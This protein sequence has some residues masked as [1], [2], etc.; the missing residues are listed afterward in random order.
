MFL[1][2]V[3]ENP[4]T[5]RFLTRCIVSGGR[6]LTVGNEDSMAESSFLKFLVIGSKGDIGPFFLKVMTSSLQLFTG[7]KI[8]CLMIKTKRVLI[9]LSYEIRVKL[10]PKP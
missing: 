3:V 8:W 7:G 6:M 1:L 5:R 2:K 4:A 10:T 9:K